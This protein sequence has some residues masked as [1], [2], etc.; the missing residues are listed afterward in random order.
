ML[1]VCRAQVETVISK[2]ARPLVEKA[3]RPVLEGPAQPSARVAVARAVRSAIKALL[4]RFGAPSVRGE[5]QLDVMP[6]DRVL[7]V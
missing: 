3:C 5:R 2:L 6:R 1:S 7:S 4:G